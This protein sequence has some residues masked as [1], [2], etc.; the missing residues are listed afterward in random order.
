[1][2]KKKSNKVVNLPKQPPSAPTSEPTIEAKDE[3]A[4]LFQLVLANECTF[5]C[6]STD[7]TNPRL[8]IG[9]IRRT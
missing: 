9:V 1:M 6:L 3:K 2:P 8:E 4:V 5:L 7:P